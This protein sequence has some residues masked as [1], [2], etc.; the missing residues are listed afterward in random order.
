MT[1]EF[2][3]VTEL[4]HRLID[5]QEGRISPDEFMGTLLDG[6]VFM[7]ILD[8]HAIKGFQD[9]TKAVPLTLEDEQG[10]QILVLFS[11]PERAREFLKQ[12]P[13]CGGGLVAE[14]R[15]ILER[16]GA[17]VGITLNPG[18]SAGFDIEA[19]AVER[20]AGSPG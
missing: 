16:M 14:T 17:G 4:E 6:Q 15:W 7:P 19:Q 2:V 10:R 13:G 5:A 12:Y 18:W 3:P 20:L 8:K 1:D 11:T 9:S